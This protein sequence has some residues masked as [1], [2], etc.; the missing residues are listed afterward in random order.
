MNQIVSIGTSHHVAPIEFREKL[1]FSEAQLT[2][3]LQHLRESFQIHEAV[4][5]ST[6]NR[7][8]LYAVVNSVRTA[9]AAAK[10]L[11]EF[12]SHYHRIGVG[13]LKKWTYL[14]HNLETIQ[15]LFRVTASLDSMVVGESQIL[16][17][18]KTAYD[19]SREASGGGAILNRLFTKAFSVGKRIRS[20]TTI[21]AGAV[22]ISYAAVELAKKIFNTLEGKTVAILG[23]G[24]MSEL[25]AKH[26]V[27]NG[28]ANVIVANRTYERAVKVAEK[29]N[30][31]PMAYD[32]DLDFLIDADIVISSTDAPDYL[33]K[34]QPLVHIMRKRKHRYMFL[35]DIAVPRDIE[36][37]VNKIDHAFLYNIDDLEAVVASNLKDRQQEANRAEQIVAEEAKRFYDQLQIFQVNPT[38][39]ALHQ[40]FREIADTELQACFYKT[41][42]SDQQE[43]AVASMTQAIVKKL[44]HHPMQNLRCAVNDGD[45]DHGQYIQALQELFA[46]DVNDDNSDV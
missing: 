3:S 38:I 26:L 15:H 14:H 24:E 27:S 5:L 21:A 42:L 23:A 17:Q 41:T 36:P 28:V 4:I 2:E 7:V 34:R 33:I 25:T 8:E 19:T 16:G 46:L 37:D 44:L 30:G 20:E 35:I 9:D 11:V 31:T 40:Q 22:S 45:A 12:L 39:K 43:A 29:F 32:S 1:A 6:C 18:V 10:M 13:S